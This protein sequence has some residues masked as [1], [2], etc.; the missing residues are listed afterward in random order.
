ML[1]SELEAKLKALREE[2]GDLPCMFWSNYCMTLEKLKKEMLSVIDT[3]GPE[4]KHKAV[5]LE[6]II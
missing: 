1:I 6:D 5:L 3:D 4:G 2:H